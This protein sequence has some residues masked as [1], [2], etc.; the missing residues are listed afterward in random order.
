M[1]S[2]IVIGAGIV[3]ASIAYHLARSGVKVRVLEANETTGGVAT[4]SSWAWINASWGNDRQYVELRMRSMD[5]WRALDKALPRLSVNWCGS[6]LWDLPEE[7][8]LA[9][10][11]EHQSWGYL[12]RVVTRKEAHI[13]EPL[14]RDLPDIAV[15]A[16]NEGSVDPI[17]AVE[18]L[19][20]AARENGALVTPSAR[21]S[22]LNEEGGRIVG[23]T[24]DK[25][26]FFADDIVSAA[27]TGSVHLLKSV[28]LDLKLE[29]P[30]GL[31]LHTHPLPAVLRGLALAP[32][33]H[34]RQTQ[35][36]R[37]VAGSDFGGADPADDP[38]A[39]AAALFE[40]L[41]GL[42]HP[43]DG[44]ALS[45]HTIGLRPSLP[46]G[47]PALGRPKGIVGLY[48]AVMHSGVTLA[49]VVGQIVLD[50]IVHGR[51]DPE[52]ERYHPDRVIQVDTHKGP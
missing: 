36:G 17:H 44:L 10:A 13:L 16:P 34:V 7:K 12:V 46:D 4:P 25:G 38:A 14:V 45:H 40:E 39:T 26:R 1:K 30:A 47:I 3:G 11:K 32:K 41:Q 28:G 8:L 5:M 31:L 49:P 50:E 42:L 22:H 27:G 48:L 37:L 52:L 23:V 35:E 21:V 43:I 6:L 2:V 51:R 33:L 18:V 15:H 29:Q 24:T 20:Q 19:L 9:F